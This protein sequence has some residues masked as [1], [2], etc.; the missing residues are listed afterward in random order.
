MKSWKYFFVTLLFFIWN[1]QAQNYD[2][3]GDWVGYVTQK[4]M[5]ISLGFYEFGLKIINKGNSNYEGKS[6]I[7]TDGD[8]W[9]AMGEMQFKANWSN[10][11]FNYKETK[12]I[13][14]KIPQNIQ[15]CLKSCNFQLKI[16]NDSLI[17]E[18]PWSGRSSYG[19]CNPGFIR[20]AKPLPIK[21]SNT[22]K[23]EEKPLLPE[24]VKLGEKFQFSAIQF[25]PSKSYLLSSSYETLDAMAD[26]LKKHP[27]NIIEI[28]GHTDKGKN[29]EYN[30]NLSQDRA[31][32]VMN[33]LVQRGVN[34]NQLK[35]K[36]YGSTKP[37]A[38]NETIEGRK[39][40]RRVEF[41]VLQ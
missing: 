2:L 27:K 26:W 20:V 9:S 24:N 35:A 17:M 23:A 12:I 39:L 13:Q 15:W 31:N 11:S 7:A 32:A 36:G 33:Y 29:Y 5:V 6:Y 25:E 4:D 28:E 19:E 3:S 22:P 10:E 30:M 38:D 1:L 18:G 14:Q 8:N 40:N 34:P 37:I 21:N 41:V 16:N